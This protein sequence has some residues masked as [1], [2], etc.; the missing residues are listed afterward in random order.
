MWCVDIIE[1]LEDRIGIMERAGSKTLLVA[2]KSLE[3]AVNHKPSVVSLKL[4]IAIVPNYRGSL[5]RF[6]SLDEFE[7]SSDFETFHNNYWEKKY[8]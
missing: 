1:Q 6:I 5:F 7:I 3:L 4:L 2:V 8:S